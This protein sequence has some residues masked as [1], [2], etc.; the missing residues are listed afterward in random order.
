MALAAIR[1]RSSGASSAE[2]RDAAEDEHPGDLVERV[3]RVWHPVPPSPIGRSAE[4]APGS[5]GPDRRSTSGASRLYSTVDRRARPRGDGR[6]LG[7]AA[8]RR[9]CRAPRWPS[10]W[11]QDRRSG[12]S[13]GSSPRRPGRRGSPGHGRA[14]PRSASLDRRAPNPGTPSSPR[15]RRPWCRAG[16]RAYVARLGARPPGRPGRRPTGRAPIGPRRRGRRAHRA[17]RIGPVRSRTGGPRA[18]G[19]SRAARADPSPGPRRSGPLPSRHPGKGRRAARASSDA[20][21]WAASTRTAAARTSGV[22]LAIPSAIQSEGTVAPDRAQASRP[23]T[24]SARSVPWIR[25]VSRDWPRF[26][27]WSR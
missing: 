7:S 22:R 19:F 16:H 18:R 20:L 23:A 21:G 11:S 15:R 9:G 4:R 5:T 1:W 24:R 14:D 10:P 17:P 12:D 8:A 2:Q 27:P 26:G 25:S 6:R 13:A 3:G